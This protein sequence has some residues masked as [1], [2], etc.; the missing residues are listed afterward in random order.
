MTL[1]ANWSVNWSLT[2]HWTY[3]LHFHGH[4]WDRYLLNTPPQIRGI[5]RNLADITKRELKKKQNREKDEQEGDADKELRWNPAK[6]RIRRSPSEID[7]QTERS[8]LI[9]VLKQLLNEKQEREQQIRQQLV[10]TFIFYFIVSIHLQNVYAW[11]TCYILLGG[12]VFQLL[13]SCECFMSND[14]CY[15][16]W[17]IQIDIFQSSETLFKDLNII[18]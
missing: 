1:K 11:E 4:S 13:T 5:Q 16:N 18:I 17:F 15:L 3:M 2:L 8:N 6:F 12:G 7:L 10:S 9:G 14:L